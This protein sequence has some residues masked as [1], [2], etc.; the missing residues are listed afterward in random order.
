VRCLFC[1]TQHQLSVEHIIPRN[2]G[3]SITIPDVCTKCNSVLGSAV[4]AEL[5]RQRHIYDGWLKIPKQ[6]RPELDFHFIEQWIENED[7]ERIKVSNKNKIIPTKIDDGHMVTSAD[8]NKTVLNVLKR[9][10]PDLT[11]DDLQRA[12]EKLSSFT[13]SQKEGD[14][15]ADAEFGIEFR[16][17]GQHAQVHNLMN[18]KTPDRFIAKVA[19]EVIQSVGL[20]DEITETETLRRHAIQG[21]QYEN[22]RFLEDVGDDSAVCPP[23]HVLKS[24]FNDFDSKW[25]FGVDLFGYYSVGVAVEWVTEPYEF[26]LAEV[27]VDYSSNGL[28]KKK[29]KY[30]LI[31][32]NDTQVK[33]VPLDM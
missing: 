19:Y 31:R 20:Q 7:G 13:D 22:L 24:F 8:D 17:L 33:W 11:A 30:M 26:N 32:L 6:Y 10:R 25:Y 21:D 4:D 29:G 3:G 12:A 15:F 18:G 1:G 16:V 9:K 28:L 14:S 27:L 2:I 5:N 23:T